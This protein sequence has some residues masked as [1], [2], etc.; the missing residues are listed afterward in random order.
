M[1]SREINNGD[2]SARKG[3]LFPILGGLTLGV[4]NIIRKYALDVFDAPILGVAIAYTFSLLPFLLMFMFS[5]STRNELSLKRDFRLFW[6]AG[7]GQAISWMWSFYALSYDAVAI[8]TPL[9]ATEPLFVVLFA[10]FYLR[11][12][13]RVSLKLV[14]SIVLTVLGV[15]L[16]II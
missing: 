10:Y 3:L 16:V 14:A 12:M 13:E 5:A 1:S 4:S 8:V 11:G 9:L 7:I 15:A 2:K 6:A